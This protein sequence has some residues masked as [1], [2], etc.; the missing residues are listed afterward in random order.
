MP[1]ERADRT[2]EDWRAIAHSARRPAEPPRPGA[3]L[4]G[5]VTLLGTAAATIGVVAV[6][7]LAGRG[8]PAVPAGAPSPSVAAVASAAVPSPS[9]AA[10]PTAPAASPTASA[11]DAPS[12]SQGPAQAP[13]TPSEAASAVTAYTQELVDGQYAKAW[14]RLGEAS[15]S[16]YGSLSAFKSE[17]SAYFASVKGRFHV[18]V[19]PPGLASMDTWLAGIPGGGAG[20]DPAAAVLVEVT[21]P[22]IAQS[23]QFDVYV[24][25]RSGSSVVIL[26]AR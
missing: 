8:G 4:A 2:L 9:S 13:V 7:V 23:N 24:V 20:I 11:T 26:I 22:A 18:E 16:G 3:S 15:R 1:Q 25:A 19:S 6:L 10:T 12:P 14:A 17:R 21:Y 5:A